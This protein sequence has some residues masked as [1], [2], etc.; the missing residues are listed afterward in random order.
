MQING[1][2]KERSRITT[3]IKTTLRTRES[4]LEVTRSK[5]EVERGMPMRFE[6]RQ[7]YHDT[8]FVLFA[9]TLSRA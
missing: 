1:K 2:L 3:T 5:L 4:A 7:L 9:E 6:Y 8:A